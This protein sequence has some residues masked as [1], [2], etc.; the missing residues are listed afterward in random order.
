MGES[1]PKSNKLLISISI[2]GES[3]VEWA[4]RAAGDRIEF[5]RSVSGW[6]LSPDMDPMVRWP[7]LRPVAVVV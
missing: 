6:V 4:M 2:G 3:P 1:K 5:H 7:V